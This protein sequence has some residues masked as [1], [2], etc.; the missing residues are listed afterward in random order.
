MNINPGRRRVSPVT[1]S[2]RTAS[3]NDERYRKQTGPPTTGDVNGRPAIELLELQ[4]A[5][6]KGRFAIKPIGPLAM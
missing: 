5:E 2:K 1:S 6:S 3:C 4:E